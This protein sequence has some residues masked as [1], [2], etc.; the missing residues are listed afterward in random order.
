MHAMKI[1]LT[2][3]EGQLGTDFRLVCGGVHDIVAHDFDLDIVDRSAV[4]DRVRE[5]SPDLVLNAAA[6]T[7]VDGAESDEIQA[8]RVNALGAHNLALACGEGGI[9]LTHV[10][11]DFVFDGEATEPYTEFDRPNPRGVYGRSKY[12]GECYVA[13]LLDRYYICR[14]SWLYG[15]GGNNF[16]KTML[17]L[18]RERDRLAV[19]DDQRGSPTYSR[20]LARKLLE[21]IDGGAYG[22]YHLSNAG[23]TTWC[24]FTR[25]ILDIAG[26]DTP[27][28][29][30]TTGELGRPA[31]RPRYSVMR[32]LSLEMQGIAPMRPYREALREFILEDLPAWQREG[33]ESR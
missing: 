29:A 1:L 11:T 3:S 18:G 13:A 9:P 30:I 24:A 14:T 23:E 4:A 25:E 22:L 15:A 8:F 7:D 21:V 31:P 16:V 17:A 12:A 33:G 26:I 28:E 10:S 32:G 6:Y 2:G 27:V 5:V 19:V 20:D